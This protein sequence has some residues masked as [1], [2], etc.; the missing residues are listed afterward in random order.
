MVHASIPRFLAA[1]AILLG[2]TSAAWTAK[3]RV[4]LKEVAKEWLDS[5]GFKDASNELREIL[6]AAEKGEKAPTAIANFEKAILADQPLD[7]EKH[8]L[9][10]ALNLLR[11]DDFRCS[12]GVPDY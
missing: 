7:P 8:S 3:I 4:P 1:I 6:V 10:V 5:E 2:L 12:V 9:A 11:L